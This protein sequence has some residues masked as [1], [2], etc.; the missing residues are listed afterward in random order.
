[1]ATDEPK[2]AKAE[3]GKPQAPKKPAAKS[4]GKKGAKP[5]YE[6]GLLYRRLFCIWSTFAFL[7]ACSFA[8]VRFFFPRM[9]FEPKTRF[10][11]GYP[12]DYSLGVDTKWQHAQ[13]IWVVRDAKGVYVIFA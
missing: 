7:A 10:R 13:R 4:K 11:I 9:L 12:A 2:P 3:E 8:T 5:R 6:G 1:M